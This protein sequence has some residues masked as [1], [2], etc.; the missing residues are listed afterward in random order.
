M[1]PLIKIGGAENMI[2]IKEKADSFQEAESI[3]SMIKACL[4]SYPQSIVTFGCKQNANSCMITKIKNVKYSGSEIT[5][6]GADCEIVIDI[7]KGNDVRQNSTGIAI[8]YPNNY[9]FMLVADKNY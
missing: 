9:Y 1:F 7:R 3:S 6:Q 2:I 4:K 5:F 8:H